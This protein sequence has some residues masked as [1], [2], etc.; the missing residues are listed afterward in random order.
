MEIIERQKLVK[1]FADRQALPK[2]GLAATVPL[3]SVVTPEI[4]KLYSNPDNILLPKSEWRP[5]KPTFNAFKGDEYTKLIL[6]GVDIGFMRVQFK[7]AYVCQRLLPGGE[8]RPG[9]SLHLSEQSIQRHVT[10]AWR[11]WFAQPEH[12]GRNHCHAR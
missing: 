2:R 4:H 9:R 1:A 6:R 8:D 11:S 12:V 3:E 7:K 10:G 5:A